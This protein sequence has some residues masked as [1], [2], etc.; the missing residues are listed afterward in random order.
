MPSWGW[1]LPMLAASVWLVMSPRTLAKGG[2]SM[3]RAPGSIS[4]DGGLSPSCV[5]RKAS[6]VPP[7]VV[8]ALLYRYTSSGVIAHTVVSG[9][10]A[11][12]AFRKA[13]WSVLIV[14]QDVYYADLDEVR[15]LDIGRFHQWQKSWEQG[16]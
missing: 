11:I 1:W 6:D 15:D 5:G 12:K 8:D 13:G 3:R 10:A 14:S 2:P 7:R 9:H 4:P 16:I